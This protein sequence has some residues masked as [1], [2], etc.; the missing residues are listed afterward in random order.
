MIFLLVVLVLFLAVL[1]KLYYRYYTVD[2]YL[3]SI[4]GPKSLSILKNTLGFRRPFLDVL[5]NY[6]Q[7]FGDTFKFETIF[8]YVGVTTRDA[9][10]IQ[11]VLNSPKLLEKG[12]SY[13]FLHNLLGNGLLTN[14]GSIWK[15]HR[16]LITPCFHYTIL[17]GF[18][19]LFHSCESFLLANLEKEVGKEVVDIFSIVRVHTLNMI[20]TS[21]MGSTIKANSNFFQN[22]ND[23]CRIFAE[24]IISPVKSMD[25]FFSLTTDYK[26]QQQAVT[27][28]HQ[29]TD[30][31]ISSRRKELQNK[32][33]AINLPV[34]DTGKKKK[35]SFLDT[36]LQSQTECSTLTDKE[37]RDEVITFMLAGY[38]TIASTLSYV[39]YS[40]AQNPD[41]QNKVVDELK[42]IFGNEK[43]TQSTMDNLLN[44]KYLEM[45]I[46]ETLRLYP[47]AP[48]ITRAVT[49][50]ITFGNI[51]FPKGVNISMSIFDLHRNPKYY[52]NPEQF[53]PERFNLE[54]IMKRP[55]C[56][57]IPFSSGMRN[58]IGQNYAILETKSVLSKILR[59]FEILP[60]PADEGLKLQAN[61]VL[62]STT[63]IKI[64]LK[65]RKF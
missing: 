10:L 28:M 48:V 57:Y 37:I 46:K 30:L 27:N 56:A 11:F 40:L 3:T 14:N 19:D 2:A 44:M 20:C 50:D 18:L 33:K 58:C 45:V 36:L 64:Q 53:D 9:D 41:V 54:N 34:D 55:S 15:H 12:N 39:L 8:L 1:I 61:V 35:L 16:K 25:L 23:L 17:E 22:I 60:S 21:S 24:R 62:R 31:I 65:Q 52:E 43:N 13:K 7:Q 47:V 26:V 51:T 63:G 5:N 42:L 4:P 32:N 38:E 49:E 6:F 29:Y 59:N